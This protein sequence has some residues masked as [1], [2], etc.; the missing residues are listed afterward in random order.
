MVLI[1]ED[2]HT[3]GVEL[4]GL[5]AA[6]LRGMHCTASFTPLST[7]AE[8]HCTAAAH[9]ILGGERLEAVEMPE[10]EAVEFIHG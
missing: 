10:L 8:V 9:D 5:Q 6:V 7:A 2:D 3:I 4:D 1:D